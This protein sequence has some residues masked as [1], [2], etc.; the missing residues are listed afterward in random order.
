M[1]AENDRID[2]PSRGAQARA[3]L[4]RKPAVSGTI[5]QAAERLVAAEAE[6]L[7]ARAIDRP[8]ASF[9][10]QFEQGAVL[11]AADRVIAFFVRRYLREQ[12][13]Q[14]P[15][16]HP[17]NRTRAIGLRA[18]P[19]YLRLLVAGQVEAGKLADHGIA[20]HPDFVG[21]LRGMR[22]RPRNGF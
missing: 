9:L 22:A 20:A 2:T 14:Q 17:G 11:F 4:I 12:F 6:A 16:L 3:G 10:A 15:K 1:P 18:R 7:V 5:G 8:A 13:S 21:D 19:P